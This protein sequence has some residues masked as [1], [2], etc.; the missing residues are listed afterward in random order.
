M[1][2][3]FYTFCFVLLTVLQLSGQT[4]PKKFVFTPE[5]SAVTWT[6][7]ELNPELPSDW[8]S[9][10]YL[11][12]RLK[13]STPQLLF[14]SIVTKGGAYTQGIHPFSCVPVQ[15]SIPLDYYRGAPPSAA[16]M[17]A[18]Y[19]K[20]QPF[21]MINLG[22]GVGPLVGVESIRFSMN[23]PMNSPAL[24]LYPEVFLAD[25]PQ[26]S[27]LQ[28]G[29]V[30]DRFG[31]WM[32]DTWND[33]VK[34]VDELLN[35]YAKED[36]E[37]QE[38]FPSSQSKYG[39]F[40]AHREAAT[41]FF[42]TKKIADKWW[43]VDPEGHLFLSTGACCIWK[44]N[45]TPSTGRE[46]IFED[47]PDT[48]D[49]YTDYYNR[50]LKRRYEADK[51]KGWRHNTQKRMRTWGLN[52][53]GNWSDPLMQQKDMPFVL[54]LQG[55]DLHRFTMGLADVYDPH[56]RKAVTKA[57]ENLANQYKDNPW[58]LGYF[59]GNEQPWP[60][61]EVLLCDRLLEGEELPIKKALMSYLKQ[62]GD[63]PENKRQFVYD[64]FE[65]F[66]ALVNETLKAADA[67]HLNLGMRFGAEITDELLSV[68]GKHVDVFSFNCYQI[69]PNR[70]FIER[71]YQITGLPSMIG[72]FH[73][74][75]SDRG[76]A[77]GLVAVATDKERGEA[78]QY[79]VENGYAHPALI[80]MHWFQWIDEPNTGRMD[81]ENYH[82]GLVDITDR[83]YLS[84]I[85][86]MQTTGRKI[87][88][89]HQ[90]MLSPTSNK[91]TH[92]LQ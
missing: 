63:S 18:T 61:Q 82:I 43:F 64:T 58:L 81:G 16:D 1:K 77:P 38:Q 5:Q 35:A 74:G 80:G 44:S 46:F 24:E 39:G 53:V 69:E 30:V 70:A 83:P 26:N 91:P 15:F 66:L 9:S 76:M 21:G 11:V 14:V 60:G 33:K 56:Y 40:K 28:E 25:E 48:V 10:N 75:V 23:M 71:I 87:F 31:Q 29:Y 68:V 90:G 54:T 50:N 6:C 49:G 59:I 55:L 17:A 85:N 8:S 19:K 51:E 22:G 86:A 20:W 92:A 42:Y 73:F 62:R 78:Y 4:T 41:G 36:K 67:N 34:T 37:L 72:E 32:F 3:V 79:Y 45:P 7:E 52:T 88:Q 13:I 89:I 2:R 27:L 57:I 65:Q 84:M 12:L 47:M